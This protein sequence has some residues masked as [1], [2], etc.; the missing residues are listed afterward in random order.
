MTK[1]VKIFVA[2]LMLTMMSVAMSATYGQDGS[3]QIGVTYKL[4][5]Q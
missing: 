4:A 2:F 5:L 1:L 3:G